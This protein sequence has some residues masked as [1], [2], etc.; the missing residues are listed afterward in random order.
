L[1]RNPPRPRFRATRKER[2][3][4]IQHDIGVCSDGIEVPCVAA[5][6]AA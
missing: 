6:A 2:D 3:M 1:R 5:K 4:S